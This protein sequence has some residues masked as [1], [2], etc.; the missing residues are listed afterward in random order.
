MHLLCK[1]RSNPHPQ[2][3]LVLCMTWTDKSEIPTHLCSCETDHWLALSSVLHQSQEF[4]LPCREPGAGRGTQWKAAAVCLQPEPHSTKER[5]NLIVVNCWLTGL[6]ARM[7][8]VWRYVSL[9]VASLYISFLS[10]WVHIYK[11]IYDA[12]DPSVGQLPFALL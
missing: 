8:L 6:G 3:C 7:L 1:S 4:R 9:G 2:F 12:G 11:N 10:L 5:R